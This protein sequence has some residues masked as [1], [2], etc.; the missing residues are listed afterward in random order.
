MREAV[1][2]RRIGFNPCHG[3]RVTTGHRVPAGE[4]FRE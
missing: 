4:N 2:D 1:A 3:I